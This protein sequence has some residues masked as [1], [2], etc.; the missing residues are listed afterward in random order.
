MSI[1]Q[2]IMC[3]LSYHPKLHVIQSFGSAQHIGC[4]PCGREMAI[5]HG[6]RVVI[7]W[8]SELSE[9]Y[10]FM[11]YDTDAATAKWRSHVSRV[12]AKSKPRREE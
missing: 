8:D 6:Q 5:H 11:G 4:P 12:A 9:M 7:P 1:W 3:K 2:R 10:Q